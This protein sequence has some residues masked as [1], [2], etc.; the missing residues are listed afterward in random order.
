MSTDTQ[1]VIFIK[2]FILFIVKQYAD[3]ITYIG[4][5]REGTIGCKLHKFPKFYNNHFLF[6]DLIILGTFNKF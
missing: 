5:E 2:T 1:P 3:V 4:T 6:V